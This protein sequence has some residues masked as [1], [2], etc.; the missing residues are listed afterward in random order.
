[1]LFFLPFL[2]KVHLFDWDE[3]NFAECAREMILTGNYLQ[4]QINFQPFFEKPPLFFWLQTLSMKVWGI[5]EYA[6]RF[7]NAVF[8]IATL[9]L[10]YKL[11][12]KHFSHRFGAI[13]AFSWFGSILPHL[14]FKS[15]IIDPVFNF[16]I[17]LSLYFFIQFYWQKSEHFSAISGRSKASIRLLIS[18]ICMA[19]AILTKGPAAILIMGLVLG[20]YWISKKGKWYVRPGAFLL[21]ALI[22]L[23]GAGIWFGLESLAHGPDFIREFVI[24]Q[25]RLFS[26]PDAGHGGFPGFHL[27]V[28]L[29]GCFPASIFAARA[30]FLKGNLAPEQQ[31]FRK[32][33]LILFWVVLVLFS[34]VQSKIVHYSSLCYFPLSFL[35]AQALDALWQKRITW[36]GWLKGS[37]LGIGGLI[38]LAA[39]AIPL[40]GMRAESLKPWIKDPSGKASLEAAVVW[41]GWESIAGLVLLVA[42]ILG[43]VFF[44]KGKTQRAILTLFGGSALFVWLSL[45]LLINKIEHYSQRA[46]IAFFESLEGK[47]VYLIPMHYKTYGHLFYSKKEPPQNPEPDIGQLIYGEIDKDVYISTKVHKAH[48]LREIEGIEELDAKNGFVFFIRRKTVEVK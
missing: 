12:K 18:A 34:I 27:V 4:P 21:F 30:F 41:T 9:M 6:A 11:G 24:Y 31:D 10:L 3:I 19:L 47:E 36:G 1:M 45:A 42:V 20:I 48:L 23:G 25:V 7:P 39:A 2:G 35:A 26:T 5:N 43:Y 8:G 13:W 14:Y 38:G 37:L 15:G 40:L 33:M 46:P 17:F 29:I 32:W 16:F 22:S 28:L 44:R